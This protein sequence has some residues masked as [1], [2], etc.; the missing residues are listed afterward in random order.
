[1]TNEEL[2]HLFGREAPY[3]EHRRG[4]TIHYLQ[5]GL[6]YTGIVRWV[7]TPSTSVRGNALPLRYFVEPLG[8]D[9]PDF[10]FPSDILIDSEDETGE[11]G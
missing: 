7:C 4:D 11:P 2:R 5:E 3:S 10:V 8:G 6:N 1:M 9:M